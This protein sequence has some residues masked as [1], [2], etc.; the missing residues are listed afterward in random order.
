[1]G[2]PALPIR[3]EIPVVTTFEDLAR[4][5]GALAVKVNRAV[6]LPVLKQRVVVVGRGRQSH[7][8]CISQPHLAGLGLRRWRVPSASTTSAARR[9]VRRSCGIDGVV[10]N[11]WPA[12]VHLW[13]D[14]Q[15]AVVRAL[16]VE[17]VSAA[18][19][20]SQWIPQILPARAVGRHRVGPPALPKPARVDDVSQCQCTQ[21]VHAGRLGWAAELGWAGARTGET[22]A[23]LLC[24]AR[25]PTRR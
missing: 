10:Q 1:M 25:R 4:E 6:L 2:F 9:A 24:N 16:G 17:T 11:D 12:A 23:T 18:V 8:L 19:V 22:R 15:A 20:R 5:A 3:Y 21:L 7:R 13:V 14:G